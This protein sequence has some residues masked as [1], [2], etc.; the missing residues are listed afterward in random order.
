ML[1][2]VE[3]GRHANCFNRNITIQAYMVHL[4][5][6]LRYGDDG[7]S[8]FVA[9]ARPAFPTPYPCIKIG[10][11]GDGLSSESPANYY[12]PPQ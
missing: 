10:E 7:V 9:L 11:I 8:F 2:R 12:L 1:G 4:H 3:V 5:M 6:L